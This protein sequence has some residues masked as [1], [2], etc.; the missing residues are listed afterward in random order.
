MT[1]EAARAVTPELNH[2]G[3]TAAPASGPDSRT[4]KVIWVPPRVA[5]TRTMSSSSRSP[6]RLCT[7]TCSAL[8]GTTRRTSNG[9]RSGSARPTA[10]SRWPSAA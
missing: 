9:M 6:G 5:G 4:R 2:I 7:V 10:S 1:V 8:R 3:T